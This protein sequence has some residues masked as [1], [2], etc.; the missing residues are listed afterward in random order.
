[1]SLIRSAGDRILSTSV[2]MSEECNPDDRCNVYCLSL[3]E[4]WQIRH[5]VK[6]IDSIRRRRQVVNMP[7]TSMGIVDQRIVHLIRSNVNMK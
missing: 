3:L 7:S 2:F 6:G 1:M 4:R 5:S